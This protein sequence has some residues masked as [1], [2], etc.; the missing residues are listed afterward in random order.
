MTSSMK[1]LFT[2]TP[3]SK[4]SPTGGINIS[5][6]DSKPAT[7]TPEHWEEIFFN[8]MVENPTPT[9]IPTPPKTSPKRELY[10]NFVLA[11]FCTRNL[12]TENLS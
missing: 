7:I 12:R 9:G 11:K 4:Y 3:T 8:V 1:N 5:E 2:S 10:P 6:K